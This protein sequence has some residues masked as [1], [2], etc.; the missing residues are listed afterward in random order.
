[1]TEKKLIS[2]SAGTFVLKWG[3]FALG[4][5]GCVL[6]STAVPVVLGAII[7]NIL[8][9]HSIEVEAANSVPALLAATIVINYLTLKRFRNDQ[10]WV[11]SVYDC[12][13]YLQIKKKKR[14]IQ[15]KIS[16]IKNIDICVINLKPLHNSRSI[17]DLISSSYLEAS[18]SLRQTTSLGNKILFI[19]KVKLGGLLDRGHSSL[20]ACVLDT[21]N[22]ICKANKILMTE[23]SYP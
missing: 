18:L 16:E 4:I 22:R 17:L 23:S 8:R 13:N 7:I 14:Q 10:K 6:L 2:S 20:D 3:P 21:L 15:V 5:I 19:P 11:D 1:M 12:G 9:T